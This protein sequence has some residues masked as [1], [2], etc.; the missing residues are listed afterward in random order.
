MVPAGPS[1][2][3][4]EGT[5]LAVSADLVAGCVASEG[6]AQGAAGRRGRRDGRDVVRCRHRGAV[7]AWRQASAGHA[8]EVACGRQRDAARA[9]TSR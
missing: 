2:R 4:Q 8:C 1:C 3:S 6:R 7:R 5:R 9:L